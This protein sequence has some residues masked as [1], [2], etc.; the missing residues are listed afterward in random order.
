MTL[1]HVGQTWSLSSKDK[2]RYG[3]KLKQII[4]VSKRGS[5]RIFLYGK[6]A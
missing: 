2:P 5:I 1:T 4:C 6:L 3:G